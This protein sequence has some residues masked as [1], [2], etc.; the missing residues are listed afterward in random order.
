M[1]EITARIAQDEVMVT[2]LP[3]EEID[4]TQ[5][6][7]VTSVN[8]AD[9]LEFTPENNTAALGSAVVTLA[10]LAVGSSILSSRFKHHRN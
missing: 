2:G 7:T 3:T 1:R 6:T 4:P 5:Q 10:I 8:T 9:S